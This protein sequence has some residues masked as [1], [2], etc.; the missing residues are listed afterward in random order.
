MLLI[1]AAMLFAAE[2]LL[3][4]PLFQFFFFTISRLY[5][6]ATPLRLRFTLILP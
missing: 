2:M 3:L 5:D 4:L 1:T 6:I